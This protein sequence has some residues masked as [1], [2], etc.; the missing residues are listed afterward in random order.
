MSAGRQLR[1]MSANIELGT[2]HPYLFGLDWGRAISVFF[3]VAPV[4]AIPVAIFGPAGPVFWTAM[5]MAA[6]GGA[7]AIGKVAARP[8]R[9]ELDW[10]DYV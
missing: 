5:G 6:I 1:R 2:R 8:R 3:W 7:R 4:V 10:R 9:R